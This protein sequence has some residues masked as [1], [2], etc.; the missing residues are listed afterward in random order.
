MWRY[1]SGMKRRKE[2]RRVSVREGYDLWAET[3]EATPNPVV[4]T[5]ARVTLPELDPERGERILDAGCGTGRNLRAI[6]KAGA[7]AVGF[8]LSL[9]ML[10]VA[11]RV[12]SNA[13][14]VQAD[15][16]KTW[17]FRKPRF[18]AILC[19]LI[20]EHLDDLPFTFRQMHGALR[21]GGRVVFSVFHPDLAKAGS[22]ANFDLGNVEYRLGA[23][24]YKTEDY[25]DMMHSAGF[26]KLDAKIH[27][28]NSDLAAAI[29]SAADLVGENV[30]LTIRA[31]RA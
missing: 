8:D 15:L 21:E 29:P 26:A 1:D 10:Q 6:E 19:A 31:E 24:Q 3:Y 20:G 9:Q 25:M 30:I 5:D 23:I 4:M 16:Q 28:G 27:K 17:P 13:H 12:Q 18:D 14:L 22:E 2:V 11:R 7:K